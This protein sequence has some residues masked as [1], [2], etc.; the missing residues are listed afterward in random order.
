MHVDRPLFTGTGAGARR[1]REAALRR[2]VLAGKPPPIPTTTQMPAALVDSARS[3]LA[4]ERLA[5][6]SSNARRR[7]DTSPMAT[8]RR[9]TLASPASRGSLAATGEWAAASRCHACVCACVCVGRVNFMQAAVVPCLAS[10]GNCPMF[11]HASVPPGR[12][13][14]WHWHWSRPSG[15]LATS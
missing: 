11:L 3:C 6:D 7:L 12:C 14:H 15:L 1:G 10:G 8:R 4:G 5:R 13:M 2:Y 9:T